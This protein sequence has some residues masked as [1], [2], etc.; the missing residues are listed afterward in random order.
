M[1][2]LVDYLYILQ[3]LQTV[4]VYLCRRHRFQVLQQHD[5]QFS[6]D[7]CNVCEI[8]IKTSTPTPVQASPDASTYARVQGSCQFPGPVDVVTTK[9]D[10]FFLVDRRN[11]TN[12]IY[13]CQ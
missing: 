3:F 1:I 8:E 11:T 6:E 10:S 2:S 13:S 4:V 12:I 7:V 9:L 5:F